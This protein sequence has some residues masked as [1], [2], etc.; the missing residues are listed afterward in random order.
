MAEDK[1]PVR[2]TPEQEL[3]IVKASNEMLGSAIDGLIERGVDQSIVDSVRNAMDENL[4]YARNKYGA[5]ESDVKNARYHGA[6]ISYIKSYEDRLRM[7]GKTHEDM[8][9]KAIASVTTGEQET[10]TPERRERKVHGVG[11]NEEDGRVVSED[12][13]NEAE[14]TP[15]QKRRARKKKETGQD[16]P[17]KRREQIETMDTEPVETLVAP[18]EKKNP[19]PER[20]DSSN[21][22]IEQFNLADIPDYVQ[23]DIIP[24]PSNGECYPHKKGRIP[25][26]Y[27]T[28][29][30]ENLIASPNMYRDGKLL[31]VMLRRKVL[32]KSINVDD[33]CS[34]DRDAIILWLRATS[35]GDEFP[36][37][38]NDAETGKTYETVVKLSSLKY[39]ELKL[40]G[41]DE[42]LLTYKTSRG[43]IIKFKYISKAEEDDI[44]DKIAAEMSDYT[45]F[46]ALADLGR[47]KDSVANVELSDESRKMVDEDIEELGT[48]LDKDGGFVNEDA[49]DA[50]PAVITEQMIRYTVSVNGNK[51]RDYIERYIEN[52]RSK[53]ALDYRNFITENRPGVDFKITVN[54]PESDG[55]GSFSTFLG[56]DDTIFINI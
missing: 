56:L 45:R 16:E 1:S 18:E 28:A 34:G 35:Y 9:R 10:E 43:D 44:R 46:T 50:Y 5:S 54:R 52:L 40:K 14:G 41:D 25:V 8:Q 42:G 36:I 31:D 7:Q 15:Q 2:Y 51:D 6:N 19:K 55:G 27:L 47:L 37:T 39:K 32:D 12:E 49:E 21:Y 22:D 13:Y 4:Q 23:Y 48:L 29:A 17:V 24:L 33:L 53:D 26:A 20:V 38:A 3:A 30:D 11:L